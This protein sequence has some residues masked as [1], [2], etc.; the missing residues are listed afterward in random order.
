M[1]NFCGE[2]EAPTQKLWSDA[3]SDFRRTAVEIAKQKRNFKVES[4]F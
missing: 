1:W 4:S 2:L 3:G